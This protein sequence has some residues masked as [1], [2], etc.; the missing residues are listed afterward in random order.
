M[1]FG[2]QFGLIRQTLG[3]AS[4]YYVR[5]GQ[6]WGFPLTEL[7][8]YMVVVDQTTLVLLHLVHWGCSPASFC[9]IA[10]AGQ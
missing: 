5:S 10:S 6:I 4:G 3:N 9:S 2:K 7:E 8:R 1:A